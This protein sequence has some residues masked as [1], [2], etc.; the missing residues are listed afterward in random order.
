MRTREICLSDVTSFGVG[1]G[2]EL[3][4]LCPRIAVAVGGQCPEALAQAGL[5]I[6]PV[7]AP[8]MNRTIMVFAAK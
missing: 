6:R 5:K 4:T 3:V 8:Q 7:G 2:M 1:G